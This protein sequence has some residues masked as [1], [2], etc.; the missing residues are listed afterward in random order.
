MK[1]ATDRA[2]RRGWLLPPDA[3]DQMRRVC[4]VQSRYPA[5][6][7]GTCKSYTPP[8]FASGAGQ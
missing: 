1:A 6:D 8:K 4:T 7:R 2:V 5:A 3:V